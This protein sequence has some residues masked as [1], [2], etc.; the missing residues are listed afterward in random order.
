MPWSHLVPHRHITLGRILRLLLIFH[1]FEIS[2]GT[3]LLRV[4]L[5]QAY[6]S[7]TAKIVTLTL[8]FVR[9]RSHARISRDL[10]S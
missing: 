9:H 7:L 5:E 4:C 6:T 2:D 10:F 8:V 1:N 3:V